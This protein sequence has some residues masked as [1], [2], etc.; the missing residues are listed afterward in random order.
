MQD[1]Y[2]EMGWSS[3]AGEAMREVRSGLYGLG[4]RPS[5]HPAW[6]GGSTTASLG[7]IGAAAPSSASSFDRQGEKQTH[8]S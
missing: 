2:I 8:L 5:L 3:Q 4:G 1:R 6:S 7:L